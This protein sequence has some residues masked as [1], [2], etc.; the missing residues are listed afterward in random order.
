MNSRI[1]LPTVVAI[2]VTVY[3]VGI[4]LHELGHVTA[5]IV[6]GGN[7]ALVSSTD[8]RGDWS[9]V[10]RGGDVLIGISGSLVNW[11]LAA[12]GYCML[13]VRK[14]SGA[15]RYFAWLLMAVNGFFA[16]VYMAASP[17][18]AFGDWVTILR[19]FPLETPL[20]V[21][22]SAMGIALTCWWMRLSARQL[23]P[24]FPAPTQAARLA[25]AYPVTL[26]SWLAGGSIAAVASLLRPLELRWALIVAIASTFGTT[27]TLRPTARLAA[28]HELSAEEG[29]AQSIG[30][31]VTWMVAGTAIG[32]AFVFWL[33]PGVAV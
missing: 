16:F 3:A 23:A 7:P 9:E 21:V 10:S 19:G 18:I 25:K 13:R 26:T 2:A 12:L 29:H 8:V 6:V 30:P 11:I 27:W 15:S 1:H 14:I 28:R 31:S 32:L 22:T 17:L 33:G 4:A 24:L 20:R 5:G